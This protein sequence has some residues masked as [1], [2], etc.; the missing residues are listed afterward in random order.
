MKMDLNDVTIIIDGID[1]T[2]MIANCN[3]RGGVYYIKFINNLKLPTP[4]T[5]VDP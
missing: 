3:K 2:R 1:K 5:G 4:I